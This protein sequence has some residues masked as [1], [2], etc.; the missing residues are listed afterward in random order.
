MP[1]WDNHLVTAAGEPIPD[2]AALLQALRGA[3][4]AAPFLPPALKGA[5]A[6]FATS[7][8]YPHALALESQVNML[9]S[10]VVIQAVDHRPPPPP[11]G[12]LEFP[13]GLPYQDLGLPPVAY[14][15]KL[16]REEAEAVLKTIDQLSGWSA[17]NVF[18]WGEEDSMSNPH[19]AAFF[20]LFK[21]A[22]RPVPR[23]LEL[24]AAQV[25]TQ[26]VEVTG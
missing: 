1:P 20:K 12:V 24:E 6:A 8:S 26:A 3:G 14:E 22:G 15:L 18:T 25:A 7:P 2:E 10:S 19:H 23:K 17:E 11:A 4:W 16:S 13:A 21:A 9:F 5:L